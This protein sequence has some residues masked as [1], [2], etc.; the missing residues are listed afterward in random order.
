MPITISKRR[1]Q[2]YLWT[3]KRDLYYDPR[4]KGAMLFFKI[5]SYF[6]VTFKKQ[7]LPSGEQLN[8]T[9]IYVP[10]FFLK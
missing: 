7:S 8:E 3:Q 4:T 2:L 9:M 10:C 1:F 5:K 6:G